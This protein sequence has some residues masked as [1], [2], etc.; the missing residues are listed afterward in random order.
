MKLL[1]Q[2]FPISNFCAF[3]RFHPLSLPIRL[4]KVFYRVPRYKNLKSFQD[5]TSQWINV[6]LG[7]SMSIPIS[8]SESDEQI[9]LVF[10][11]YL[12]IENVETYYWRPYLCPSLS[13][14]PNAKPWKTVIVRNL[15]VKMNLSN[16]ISCVLCCWQKKEQKC[17]IF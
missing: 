16:L 1:L 3:Q 13:S 6:P 5:C 4:I 10:F 9:S 2:T 8:V 12:P 14:I 7:V 15:E 17:L 11:V